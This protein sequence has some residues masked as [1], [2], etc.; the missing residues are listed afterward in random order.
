MSPQGRGILEQ[1]MY[2]LTKALS[3]AIKKKPELETKYFNNSTL[4]NRSKCKKQS[5]FSSKLFEKERRKFYSN[6]KFSDINDIK[7]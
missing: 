5:N 6:L 4:E 7:P 3:K 2:Q 1:I